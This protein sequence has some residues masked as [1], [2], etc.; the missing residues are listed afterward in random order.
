MRP[1]L[2]RQGHFIA[3]SAAADFEITLPGKE[4][5]DAFATLSGLPFTASQARRKLVT[6]GVDLNALVGRKFLVEDVRRHGIRLCEPCSYLARTT[7]QEKSPAP[8]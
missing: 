4:K 1:L 7:F 6:E 3:G 5:I 8:A 2:L